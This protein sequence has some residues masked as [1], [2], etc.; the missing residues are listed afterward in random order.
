MIKTNQISNLLLAGFVFISC[1]KLTAH[2]MNNSTSSAQKSVNFTI[3]LGQGGFQDDRSPLG[4][5]GGGQLALDVKLAKFPVAFSL[6]GEYY[7]NSADPT[8][9]YEIS[10]VTAVNL[11][12]MTKP[13]KT[14]RVTFFAGSGIGWLQVPK[15]EDYPD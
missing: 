13:F 7:T 3:R 6:T 4:K 11:L 15:R 2:E 1:L 5:L 9:P 8:H 14:E 10:D 12:Y